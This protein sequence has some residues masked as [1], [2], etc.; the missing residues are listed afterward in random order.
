[1]SVFSGAKS[2]LI[3]PSGREAGIIGGRHARV[4]RLPDGVGAG[5]SAEIAS[6][7]QAKS[8]SESSRAA[9]SRCTVSLADIGWPRLCW[10]S[11]GAE[12]GQEREKGR[13]NSNWSSQRRMRR[14]RGDG[15]G[16]KGM[17]SGLRSEGEAEGGEDP[18]ARASQWHRKTI[19]KTLTP[20]YLRCKLYDSPN[21]AR[22]CWCR[23]ICMCRS[24]SNPNDGR[25]TSS[26]RGQ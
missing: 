6:K 18:G 13:R 21:A 9:I 24:C 3:T 26:P 8:L 15:H 23:I 25:G 11:C 5:E 10:G 4:D 12:T 20:E 22:W 1:M 7:V 16:E 2:D 19:T 17:R 14:S